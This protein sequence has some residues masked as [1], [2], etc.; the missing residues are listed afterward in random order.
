MA[1]FHY[2]PIF[3]FGPD[4][5]PYRRLGTDG[6]STV[7]MN[8]HEML[9][10]DAE[11]LR[12]VARQAFDDVSHLLRPGHLAQLRS[13][14]DDP[15][16]SGND[17]F[18]ALELLRNANIA[19]G[20]V[21]PGCQDTGT[22]IV[23]GH[24]GEQVLTFGDDSVALSRGIYDAYNERNL[25]YSQLAPLDMYT[26]TNTGSNLPAQ[27]EIHAEPGDEYELLFIAKGGRLG[28]QELSLSGNEGAAEPDVDAPVRRGEA[29]DDWHVRL[30]A[31]PPGPRHRWHL[32]RVHAQDAEAG[33]DEVPRPP[34]DVRQRVR[35]RV[36]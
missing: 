8:G 19:A 5:T 13:I 6:V 17:K 21:L 33:D 12:S 34:A 23:M 32:R 26:E 14:L 25:R 29:E 18:V 3:E 16:A 22:A 11:V 2:Q 35:P 20:R 4:E 9:T 30:S 27:I 1:S 15:E 7:M 36:P 24:K 31:V 28:E 10:V